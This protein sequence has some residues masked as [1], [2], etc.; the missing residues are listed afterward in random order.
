MERIEFYKMSVEEYPNHKDKG[1]LIFS[2][3][4]LKK[5][6]ESSFKYI[7]YL[8]DNKGEQK[9]IRKLIE[10]YGSLNKIVSIGLTYLNQSKK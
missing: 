2:V 7:D 4:E 5:E 8:E 9:I 10:E 1:S 6:L 3:S